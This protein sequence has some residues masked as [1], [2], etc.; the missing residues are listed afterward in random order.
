MV[1]RRAT[2]AISD[3]DGVGLRVDGNCVGVLPTEMVR[4]VAEP[5]EAKGRTSVAPIVANAVASRTVRVEG[6]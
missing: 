3:L 4:L 1:D 6:V 2:V 5:A